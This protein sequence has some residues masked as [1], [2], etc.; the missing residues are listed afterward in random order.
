MY[1]KFLLDDYLQDMNW[2]D[3]LSAI[4]DDDGLGYEISALLI[5]W[6]FRKSSSIYD[7][8]TFD[9]MKMN[10]HEEHRIQKHS[11]TNARH[12]FTNCYC[13]RMS[14]TKALT[15]VDYRSLPGGP[16][17]MLSSPAPTRLSSAHTVVRDAATVSVTAS[18][19]LS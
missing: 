6:V 19:V 16:A 14:K 18:P 9:D 5:S 10:T 1:V 13:Q 4:R 7:W 15:L 8:T 3:V 12:L 11:T 2:S 17:N